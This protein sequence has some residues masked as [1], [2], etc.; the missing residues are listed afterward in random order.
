MQS[1][2]EEALRRCPFPMTPGS[3]LVVSLL[4]Y[5]ASHLEGHGRGSS[6]QGAPG[7]PLSK[8]YSR[9]VVSILETLARTEHDTCS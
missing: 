1:G 4:A 9:D 8:Q 5:T 6:S 3:G 7:Q 2:A